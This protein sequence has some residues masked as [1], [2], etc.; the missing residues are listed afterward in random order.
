MG[1]LLVIIAEK[2]PQQLVADLIKINQNRKCLCSW[3]MARLILIG[4]EGPSIEKMVP[5][6]PVLSY[7][8]PTS[9]FPL[10]SLPLLSRMI[11][12]SFNIS[13]DGLPTN[14]GTWSLWS[15][16]SGLNIPSEPQRRLALFCGLGGGAF[17][18]WSN[19]INFG[20]SGSKV[21]WLIAKYDSN[22]RG[23]REISDLPEISS[24]CTSQSSGSR[25]GALCPLISRWCT[26]EN[27]KMGRNSR[28]C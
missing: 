16:K 19:L 5:S 23:T 4:W 12:F 27:I 14:L 25:R 2:K 8:V 26:V 11:D 15:P 28:I 13:F 24:V 17:I 1:I 9:L 6:R 3:Y 22:Y 7:L 20:S 18:F 21:V 10:Y